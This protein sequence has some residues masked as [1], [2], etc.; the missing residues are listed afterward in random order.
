ME[1]KLNNYNCILDDNNKLT[2]EDNESKIIIEHIKK[3]D[4]INK[5]E[6]CILVESAKFYDYYV[7]R[8]IALN[9]LKLDK[10]TRIIKQKVLTS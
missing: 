5:N 7:L 1:I 3:I 2:I 9:E 4:I 10:F 6:F 8:D